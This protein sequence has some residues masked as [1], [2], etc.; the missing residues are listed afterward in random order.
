MKQIG[1]MWFPDRDINTQQGLNKAT[2]MV[3]H[4]YYFEAIEEAMS[5]ATDYSV[6]IDGGANV[7]FWAQ[8]ISEK[9]NMV[10]AFE[11]D[12]ETFGCLEKN[13][14]DIMAQNCGLSNVE[15]KKII[16]NGRNGKSM[17][18]HRSN[19]IKYEFRR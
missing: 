12:R 8:K 1:H 16:A 14:P 18:D 7:G 9:F 3:K 2:H 15:G 6:A 19:Y 4:G 5:Y 13:C 17:C 11:I 10:N